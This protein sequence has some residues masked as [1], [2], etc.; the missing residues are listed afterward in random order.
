MNKKYLIIGGL[1]EDLLKN[2]SILL[3]KILIKLPITL[4]IEHYTLIERYIA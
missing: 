2:K 1:A 3:I 4:L